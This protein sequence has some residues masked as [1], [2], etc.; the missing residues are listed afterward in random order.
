MAVLPYAFNLTLSAL[1]LQPYTVSLIRAVYLQLITYAR[2]IGRLFH[3]TPST[4]R[5]QPYAFNLVQ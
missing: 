5:R 2:S 3:L 1:R 4:L